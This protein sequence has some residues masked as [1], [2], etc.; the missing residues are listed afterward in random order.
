[1]LASS[2]LFARKVVADEQP[3]LFA[4]LRRNL[5]PAHAYAGGSVRPGDLIRH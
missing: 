1:M 2:D 3:E 4:A 5:Q